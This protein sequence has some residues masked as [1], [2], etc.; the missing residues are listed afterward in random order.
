[1]LDPQRGMV[2]LIDPSHAR[3]PP[4][5]CLG[6]TKQQERTKNDEG[7][8]SSGLSGARVVEDMT[9]VAAADIHR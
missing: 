9:A 3:E 1:M 5:C 8:D 4:E 2:G 7:G 6:M